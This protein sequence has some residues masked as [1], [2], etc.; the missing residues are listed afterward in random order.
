[1]FWD[2]TIVVELS[3]SCKTSIIKHVYWL[4][5]GI[6]RALSFPKYVA[7]LRIIVSD[8]RHGYVTYVTKNMNRQ[9]LKVFAFRQ[10]Y[11][12]TIIMLRPPNRLD[13]GLYLGKNIF[14]LVSAR[15]PNHLGGLWFRQGYFYS[16]F[17]NR[18]PNPFSGRWELDK[19][20]FYPILGSRPPNGFGGLNI[21]AGV[22]ISLSKAREIWKV[23][24]N[25]RLLKTALA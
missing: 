1:M 25:C 19:N 22:K 14:T 6:K 4:S 3:A 13:R 10:G 12:L 23:D 17:I 15:P 9:S 5:I 2:N 21:I 7:V 20:I 16:L 18:P 8:L 11:L 24:F